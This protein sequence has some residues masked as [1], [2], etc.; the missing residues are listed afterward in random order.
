MMS[1][2]MSIVVIVTLVDLVA[3]TIIAAG[4]LL[5]FWNLGWG[6]LWWSWLLPSGFLLIYLVMDMWITYEQKRNQGS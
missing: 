4:N 3:S 6:W 2:W 5:G 1:R